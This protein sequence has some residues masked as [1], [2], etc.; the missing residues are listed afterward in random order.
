MSLLLALVERHPVDR[1]WVYVFYSDPKYGRGYHYLTTKF[2]IDIGSGKNVVKF[3][4]YVFSLYIISNQRCRTS[5][6]SDSIVFPSLRRLLII[7]HVFMY[8]QGK[9]PLNRFSHCP[10]SPSLSDYSCYRCGHIVIGTGDQLFYPSKSPLA[11]RQAVFKQG[12][13]FCDRYSKTSFWSGLL[14]VQVP[15]L[16]YV[17]IT[18]ALPKVI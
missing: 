15:Q 8:F 18:P 13:N 7:G 3:F 17:L 2:E 16:Y 9:Q 4:L 1:C 14:P 5:R 6:S 10:R 12:D 11:T